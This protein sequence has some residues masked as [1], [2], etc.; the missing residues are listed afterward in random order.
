MRTLEAKRGFTLVEMLVALFIFAL[1][2][3]AGV[4]MMRF[5]VTSQ[6]AVRAHTDRT[7]EF[8]ALRA[9]L[10]S[11]L[12]QA[13]PRRVRDE[14]GRPVREAFYGGEPEVLL[15]LVRRGWEN[16][17][18]AARASIQAVEYRLDEGRLI[19]RSRAAADGGPWAEPQ[20]LA[21]GVSAA[22]VAFLHRGQWIAALPG[23][24][25]EPL[26][27]AVRFDLT[28]DGVGQ[29]SQLFLVSGADQ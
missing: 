17:D 23:G 18:A 29:V 19:R 15:R 22:E 27:Q 21:Q 5:T 25:L 7:A 26:P 4:A 2:S 24:P 16:P 28:L 13:A 14:A 11:D 12:S 9:I 3:S 6:T 10:R 1:L 8:Q 20:V